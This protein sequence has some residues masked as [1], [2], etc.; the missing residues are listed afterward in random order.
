VGKI[1]GEKL[2]SI[3]IEQSLLQK[4]IAEEL[5]VSRET[6][7]YWERGI[8]EPNIEKILKLCSVLKTTPNFLLDYDD[9]DNI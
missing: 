2:K 3:R 5:N 4:D 7:S 1:F 6:V 8:K 9:N